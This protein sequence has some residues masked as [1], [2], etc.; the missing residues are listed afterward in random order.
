MNKALFLDRDGV[1]NV[2]HGYVHLPEQF[3]FIDGIFDICRLAQKRGYL[4]IV[5]TNQ[6]GI[7][8]GYYSEQTFLRLTD[9]M[10]REFNKEGIEIAE[11]YFCPDHPEHG[12]GV[13]KK[14][15]AFRKP[16]PGMLLAAAAAFDICLGDSVLVGDKSSDIEAGKAAGITKNILFSSDISFDMSFL[17]I[18]KLDQL[19]Y[20]L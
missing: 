15:S 8:R 3:D 5:V 17:R 19:E 18:D 7:G 13:Y 6:A 14:E 2:N 4:I 10:K 16:A 12:I 1:I 20:W 11:V 9:W